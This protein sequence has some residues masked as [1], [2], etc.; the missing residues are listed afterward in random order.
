LDKV[1]EF[2]KTTDEL[3]GKQLRGEKIGNGNHA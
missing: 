2:I 3:V 1:E